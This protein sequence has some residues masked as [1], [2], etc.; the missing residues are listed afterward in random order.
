MLSGCECSGLV[1]DGPAG[2]V[3]YPALAMPETGAETSITLEKRKRTERGNRD[4][5]NQEACARPLPRPCTGKTGTSEIW[6]FAGPPRN[7]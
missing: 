7:G 2:I 6:W 1:I 3:L 4:P 5:P